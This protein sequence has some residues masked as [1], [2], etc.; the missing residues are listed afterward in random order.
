MAAIEKLFKLGCGMGLQ[1]FAT[2]KKH[3]RIGTLHG[4]R[5]IGLPGTGFFGGQPPQG[6]G[7]RKTD[8]A[9][10]KDSFLSLTDEGAAEIMQ[11][12]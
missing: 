2:P 6:G 12:H 8:S 9:E 10:Q 4:T 11:N 7:I 3:Q 1:P 5:L